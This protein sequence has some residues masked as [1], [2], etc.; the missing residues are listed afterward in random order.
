MKMSQLLGVTTSELTY[1]DVNPKKGDKVVLD[2]STKIF[3]NRKNMTV[4]TTS[5]GVTR[6]K[7]CSAED[8]PTSVIN[9]RSM[10]AIINSSIH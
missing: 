6:Q 8:F 5:H 2:G 7:F 3:I 9:A 1:Q 10:A 4:T